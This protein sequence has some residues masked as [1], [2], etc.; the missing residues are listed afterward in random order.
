[1]RKLYIYMYI[2]IIYI[3]I[4]Y[5]YIIYIYIIYIWIVESKSM[6]INL[7]DYIY[8]LYIYIYIYIYLHIYIYIHI[9]ILVSN[10][11]ALNMSKNTHI[12][13]LSILKKISKQQVPQRT[14]INSCFFIWEICKV[15]LDNRMLLIPRIFSK[16][17]IF[18]ININVK[19]L[20]N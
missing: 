6:T 10:G 12:L 2:Y 18:K 20:L 8:I 15:Y 17:G 5:I 19:F 4:T 9:N 16:R 3:Y 7:N 13:P 14:P 1:M 11:N